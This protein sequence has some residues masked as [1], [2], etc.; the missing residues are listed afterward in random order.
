VLRLVRSVK[1]TFAPINRIPQEIFSLIPGYRGTEKALIALTH[2]CRGWREQLISCSSLWSSLDCASVDRT[3][4]YLERSKTSPLDIC[5]GE[6]RAPF[7][8]DAFLL[9]VPHRD[10]L[11]SLS[12]TASSNDL[13]ELTKHF[14]HCRAPLL[15]KLRIHSYLWIPQLS[16]LPY[17]TETSHRYASYGCLEPL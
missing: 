9:T 8:Q 6:G 15:E 7:L 10:R 4:V 13:V 17:S 2:V 11:K 1:N 12:I 5:L 3:R 14:L 16:K